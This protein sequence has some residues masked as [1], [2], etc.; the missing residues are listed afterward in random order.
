MHLIHVCDEQSI[1]NI[2]SYIVSIVGQ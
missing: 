2:T 1:I